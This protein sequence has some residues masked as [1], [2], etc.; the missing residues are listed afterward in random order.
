M[1][2]MVMHKHDKTTEEGTIPSQEFIGKMG[3]LIGGMAKEG[4][5][6]D[7]DGLGASKNRSRLTF[8]G[9]GAPTVVHG[10]FGGSTNELPA[11]FVKVKVQSRD[12][13]LAH[14]T[15]LG[16]AIGGPLEME[17]SL[18][19]EAWDLGLVE[20]PA[21]APQR[22][23][24]L[25]KATPRTEA[26]EGPTMEA[27]AKGLESKGVLLGA[28]T[29]APSSKAK[30]LQWKNKKR[31]VIDGPFTESR[32]LV[33]GFAIL[34]L[35]SLEECVAFANTYAELLLTVVESLEVDVRPV[36]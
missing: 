8:S 7:G 24:L 15:E 14:A 30:R 20:K 16:K 22:Y 25:P 33:G 12:E 27:L 31:T 10:P 32:E 17:V 23:L 21:N 6:L 2:L 26:G 9:S 29:L 34:E 35:P 3:A 5:L 11:G 4:R 19:N 36:R 18:I 13:A 1:K 28:A